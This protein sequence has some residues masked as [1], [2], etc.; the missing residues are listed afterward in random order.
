MNII[1]N[2]IASYAIPTILLT[3]LLL[4]VFVFS[5]FVVYKKICKREKKLDEAKQYQKYYSH[6]LG[7]LRVYTYF[8]GY[9]NRGDFTH[10]RSLLLKMG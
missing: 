10:F 7:K 8:A 2:L 3:L 5:Y 1:F 4:F 6:N 9:D